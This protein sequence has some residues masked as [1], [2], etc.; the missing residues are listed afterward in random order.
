MLLCNIVP[1][2]LTI[3]VS[4][5]PIPQAKTLSYTTSVSPNPGLEQ[6]SVHIYKENE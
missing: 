1:F 2:S 4:S 5:P 6:G 3:P